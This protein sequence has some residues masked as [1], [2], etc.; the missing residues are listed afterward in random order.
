MKTQT[1]MVGIGC[2]GIAIA[3]AIVFGGQLMSPNL[4]VAQ[5]RV[6]LGCSCATPQLLRLGQAY[7]TI[8]HCKCGDLQ[9]VVNLPGNNMQCS[10]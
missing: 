10:K 4:A 8:A 2:L 9:C 3:V 1:K 6:A 7:T 5:A